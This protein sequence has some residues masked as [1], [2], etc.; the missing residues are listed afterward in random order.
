MLTLGNIIYSNC[1]PVHAGIITGAVPF[2]FKLRDGIPSELNRLLYEGKIDVSPSSSIEFAMNPGRYAVF[3]GLSITARAMVQSIILLS[4]VP[5]ADLDDRNV[6]LTTA[7][8]TSVVLLRVLLELREGISP[9]YFLYEQGVEEPGSNADAFLTIGD[10]ALQREASEEFP[11][12]YD[13]GELWNDFTGLPFVFAL[14]QVNYRKN[15]ERDLEALFQALNASKRL[16]L[17]NL[18]DLAVAH[19]GRFGLTSAMLQDYW[20]AFSYDLGEGEQKG[21][22]TFYGYAAELGAIE[23]VPDLRIWGQRK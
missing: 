18:R 23:K 5:L 9:N 4:R 8:A 16:G 3:P 11:H 6:A 12:R 22:L 17:A 15:A 19:A 13:L 14:W 2:P 20:S 1:F 7:S 21:L 10:L